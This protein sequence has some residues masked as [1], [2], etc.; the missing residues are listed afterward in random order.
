[1]F[2]RFH[3]YKLIKTIARV[4]R[5]PPFLLAFLI[6]NISFVLVFCFDVI[7]L[8]YNRMPFFDCISFT[9]FKGKNC[10][11]LEGNACTAAVLLKL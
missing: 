3:V 8:N 1:M 11:N 10:T 9:N 4:I 5:I 6:I 2:C 7:N